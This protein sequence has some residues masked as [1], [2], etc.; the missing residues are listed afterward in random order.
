MLRCAAT[1]LIIDDTLDTRQRHLLLFS[2]VDAMLH[3]VSLMMLFTRRHDDILRAVAA[4]TRRELPML[5][6]LLRFR[7]AITLFHVTPL[8]LRL[9]RR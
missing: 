2:P 4:A 5:L 3:A 7:K 8:R 9:F 1:L 6:M